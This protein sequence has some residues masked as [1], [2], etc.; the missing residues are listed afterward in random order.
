M[1]PITKVD[2][3][4][5]SPW[6]TLNHEYIVLGLEISPQ[7]GITVL[8]QSDHYNEPISVPLDGFEIVGQKFPSNWSAKTKDNIYRIMPASWMYDDFFKDLED[9]T[10]KA[11]LLFQEESE[12]I[13]REEGLI[14]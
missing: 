8:L 11:M 4:T 14:E 3:G 6:L 5:F 2:I 12:V 7:D 13:Y 1:N 10:E 9:Q